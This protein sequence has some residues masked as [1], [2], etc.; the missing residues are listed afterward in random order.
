MSDLLDD[1]L[2]RGADEARRGGKNVVRRLVDSFTDGGDDSEASI[3]IV[4]DRSIVDELNE[5]TAQWLRDT[6]DRSEEPLVF[7]RAEGDCLEAVS[8]QSDELFVRPACTLT[9]DGLLSTSLLDYHRY[10]RLRD[11]GKDGRA[12]NLAIVGRM[13]KL[14]AARRGE[15]VT[16]LGSWF[17]AYPNDTPHSAKPVMNVEVRV[18]VDIDEASKTAQ[19]VFFNRSFNVF[20]LANPFS[21]KIGSFALQ[22]QQF[23]A[24]A[25]IDYLAN[26]RAYAVTLSQQVRDSIPDATKIADRL[27]AVRSSRKRAI[28]KMNG[29]LRPLPAADFF[30][31][32]NLDSANHALY[33]FLANRRNANGARKR[34]EGVEL[35]LPTAGDSSGSEVMVIDVD[36]VK[37][38]KDK[39][40]FA[41]DTRGL[42]PSARY[43]RG[44]T[45]LAKSIGY[46]K[47]VVDFPRAQPLR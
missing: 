26:E 47:V 12:T 44:L 19:F 4:R 8:E 5:D 18:I 32:D 3:D 6:D 22:V 35:H 30:H 24:L 36:V 33:A 21:G 40:L 10:F 13:S 20:K 9:H 2:R 38:C 17:H 31:H 41:V 14:K 23:F 15:Q 39:V 37:A 29:A 43:V 46:K 45:D 34:F 42:A 16:L 7:Q 25:I 11:G 1:F 27:I 28:E